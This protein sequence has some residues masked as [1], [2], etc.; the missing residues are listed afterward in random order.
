MR[1]LQRNGLA[2]ATAA[3]AHKRMLVLQSEVHD[4]VS[5]L[6]VECR[7]MLGLNTGRILHNLRRGGN[8]FGSF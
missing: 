6:A 3:A 2:D 7:V 4:A 1:L 8:F 5:S